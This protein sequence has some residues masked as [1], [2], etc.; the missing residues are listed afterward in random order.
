MR[1]G[2]RFESLYS[3]V[4][5]NSCELHPNL[6]DVVYHQ[7]CFSGGNL[8]YNRGTKDAE[9]SKLSLEARHAAGTAFCGQELSFLAPPQC[10]K[11]KGPPRVQGEA[12]PCPPWSRGTCGA[13]QAFPDSCSLLPQ[14]VSI[15]ARLPHDARKCPT[16]HPP[17]AD[18]S[19]AP[20]ARLGQKDPRLSCT[21]QC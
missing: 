20:R 17:R 10:P 1:H 21:A 8:R 5:S 12:L 7:P 15:E 9:R 11:T 19:A 14:D 13:C 4:S 6:R 3:H 2:P 18:R 16:P